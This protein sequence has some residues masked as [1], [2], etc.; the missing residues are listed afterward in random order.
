MPNPILKPI[1]GLGTITQTRIIDIKRRAKGNSRP[2]GQNTYNNDRYNGETGN[3]QTRVVEDPRN[4]RANENRQAP[5]NPYRN[6]P[7]NRSG[8]FSG[9]NQVPPR[10]NP[11]AGNREQSVN[12]PTVTHRSTNQ[13]N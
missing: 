1:G 5:T 3:R 8:N 12:R 9:R 2:S 10:V 11:P 6:F 13:G 7:P 4:P